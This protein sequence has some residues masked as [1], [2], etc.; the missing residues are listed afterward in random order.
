MTTR[1]GP[2]C[3]DGDGGSDSSLLAPPP[4]LVSFWLDDVAGCWRLRVE[5]PDLPP[6]ERRDV[7]GAASGGVGERT[8]FSGSGSVEVS[9][10][11]TDLIDTLSV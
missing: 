5:L 11:V 9:L 6:S 10:S 8:I 4:L 1:S 2:Q 3:L 7:L